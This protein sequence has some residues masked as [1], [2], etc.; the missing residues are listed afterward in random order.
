MSSILIHTPIK[1]DFDKEEKIVQWKNESILKQWSWHH[2]ILTCRFAHRSLYIAM[3]KTLVQ[4]DQKLNVKPVT[5]NNLEEK[6]KLE[7]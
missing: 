6:R 3:H 7:V 1:P 5:L 2:W 4:M